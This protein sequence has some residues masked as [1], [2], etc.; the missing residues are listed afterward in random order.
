MA[1]LQGPTA[2][3]QGH[4]NRCGRPIAAESA[5]AWAVAEGVWEDVEEAPAWAAAEVLAWAMGAAEDKKTLAETS[6]LDG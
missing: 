3:S 4:L 6:P 2:P 1:L 5:W